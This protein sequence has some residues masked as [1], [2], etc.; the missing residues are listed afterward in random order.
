MNKPQIE[1]R[2]G[3]T[4]AKSLRKIKAM[5]LSPDSTN[6]ISEGVYDVQK[7]Q[8]KLT[9]EVPGLCPCSDYICKRLKIF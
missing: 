3:Y 7:V 4:P 6:R 9:E 1:L 8:S 5:K 2:W